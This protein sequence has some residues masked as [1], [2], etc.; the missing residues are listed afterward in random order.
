MSSS[1]FCDFSVFAFNSS[2]FCF[3]I[4]TIAAL[5]DSVDDRFR[6]ERAVEVEGSTTYLATGCSFK[7]LSF[8][9]RIGA[10]TVGEIVRETVEIIWQ[11]LQP[12]YMPQPT[13]T[14]FKAI[15]EDFYKIWNFPN[16]IGTIDGK[17]VRIL[18]PKN[19]GSMFFNYK[20]LQGVVD[21]NYQF[22]AIDVGGYGKQSDGGTFQASDFYK[23]LI[24]NGIH[25]PEPEFLPGTNVKAPYVFLADEAYPLLDF[26]MKPY[27]G[28]NIPL[29]QECFNNRLSRARKS[30]ECA[31]GILYAKWRLISKAIET[32]V[33]TADKIVR[34]VCILH[35]LVLKKRRCRTSSY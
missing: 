27:K 31:F 21:A 26:L 35:N 13:I 16:V 34:C 5:K 9:F 20:I 19:S 22:I 12:E 25:L 24:T 29:D 17:H 15:S 6:F 4:F 11:E 23:R 10:S 28:Q 8:S 18:C 1:S 33:N 7:S 14:Q 30:V 2:N 32:D 3:S